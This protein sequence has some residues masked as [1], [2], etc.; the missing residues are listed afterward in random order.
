MANAIYTAVFLT[1]E[2]RTALL[3]EFPA[4]HPVVYADHV[5]LWFK[6]DPEQVGFIA[7]E[8]AKEQQRVNFQVVEY[9]EDEKGQAVRVTFPHVD[10]TGVVIRNELLHITISCAEGTSP[11]YSNELLKTKA[12]PREY[13]N[14]LPIMGELGVCHR[15]DKRYLPQ[16]M[17]KRR[18]L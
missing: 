11:V 5:T 7:K 9:A 13:R 16:A 4:K 2:D 1:E 15:T 10:W 6:P 14:G 12:V 17:W 18:G 3:K 8:N